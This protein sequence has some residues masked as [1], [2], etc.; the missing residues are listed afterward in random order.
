MA[1]LAPATVP[2][3]IEAFGGPAKFARVI[4]RKPSTAGE[5]KRNGSI[6]VEYWDLIIAAAETEGIPGV[7]YASLA[8]MHIPP[9]L[10]VPTEGAAA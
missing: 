4:G 2:D 3:L 8:R 5:Q 1:K 9:E 6:P 7:T 10:R